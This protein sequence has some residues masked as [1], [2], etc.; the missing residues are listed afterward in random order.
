MPVVVKISKEEAQRRLGDVPDEYAFLCHDGRRL[1]NLV[2]LRDALATMS[3]DVFAY[4][5][6]KEKKDFSNWVRDVIKDARLARQLREAGTLARARK[7][8]VQRVAFL[9]SKV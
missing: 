6:N 7:L 9:S 3:D 4:H 2:Q 5:S 1:R 8:T